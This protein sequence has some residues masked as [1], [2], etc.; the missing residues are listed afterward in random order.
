TQYTPGQSK[1]N[2]PQPQPVQLRNSSEW[3]LGTFQDATTASQVSKKVGGITGPKLLNVL[4]L[5]PIST[6]QVSLGYAAPTASKATTYL[7]AYLKAFVAN[8]RGQLD[9]QITSTLGSIT[10]QVERINRAN[11]TPQSGLAKSLQ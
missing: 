7:N 8:Y 6:S 2:F 11:P 10:T 4:Q 9:K 1:T 3:T 5:T